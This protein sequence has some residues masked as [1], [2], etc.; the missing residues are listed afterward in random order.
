MSQLLI[1]VIASAIVIPATISVCIM[2][3]RAD[4]AFDRMVVQWGER[5]SLRL[6]K[7]ERRFAMGTPFH[8]P[9][10][11][12][13]VYYATIEDVEH[14]VRHCWLRCENHLFGG[15]RIKVIWDDEPQGFPI[16]QDR[17]GND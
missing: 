12:Q 16:L 5:E 3:G 4:Q 13:I 6:L 1:V 8:W 10:R 7:F 2:Y 17:A 9:R 14:R 15:K 11:G